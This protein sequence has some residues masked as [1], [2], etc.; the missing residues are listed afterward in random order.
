MDTHIERLDVKVDTSIQRVEDQIAKGEVARAADRKWALG[1]VAPR[2]A[3]ASSVLGV[4][5]WPARDYTR[6]TIEFTST[7]D[8]CFAAVREM[9]GEPLAIRIE[10]GAH[11]DDA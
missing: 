6:V 4:R 8:S 10:V 7:G 1:L 9:D 5:V 3:M 2:L 11:R